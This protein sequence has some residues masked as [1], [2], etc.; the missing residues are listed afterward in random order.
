MV[1]LFISR[2]G[3]ERRKADVVA[4]RKLAAVAVERATRR[5]PDGCVSQGYV[6]MMK[7]PLG[8]WQFA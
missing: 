8:A 7:E 5:E 3:A 2:D 1:D 6:V 4:Q